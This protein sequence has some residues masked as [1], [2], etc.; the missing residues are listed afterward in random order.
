MT[1]LCFSVKTAVDFRL[2][3]L[4]VVKSWT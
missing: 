2:P 3:P 4:S 1:L